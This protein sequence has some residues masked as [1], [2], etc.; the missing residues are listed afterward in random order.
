MLCFYLSRTGGFEELESQKR[1]ASTP[2]VNATGSTRIFKVSGKTIN[3]IE[4][5]NKKK[6]VKNHH[7]D[8][9]E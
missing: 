7:N 5:E 3:V 1:V 9:D 6:I 2:L 4:G 8:D